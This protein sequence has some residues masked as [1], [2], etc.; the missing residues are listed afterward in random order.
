MPSDLHMSSLDGQI[1][2]FLFT[3]PQ[4]AIPF[5]ITQFQGCVYRHPINYSR[6]R[7]DIDDILLWITA[8]FNTI[9]APRG[10]K[11]TSYGARHLQNLKILAPWDPRRD[12]RKD[13]I[14]LKN[15]EPKPLSGAAI[16]SAEP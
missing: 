5:Q 13:V 3:I 8:V 14:R 7:V 15:A 12:R 1:P 6:G 2:R 10:I 9:P 16:V 11:R 4:W